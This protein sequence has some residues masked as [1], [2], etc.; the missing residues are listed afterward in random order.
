M[1]GTP[2]NFFGN[3]FAFSKMREMTRPYSIIDNTMAVKA[4]SSGGSL[5]N[6]SLQTESAKQHTTNDASNKAI[7]IAT[8][9]A[10]NN[11]SN[12][13]CKICGKSTKLVCS[14]C[15]QAWYCGKTCQTEDWKNHKLICI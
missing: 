9:N 6:I 8:N 1:R 12:N 5:Q 2:H 13:A 4:L 7:N 3:D 10:A 11:T 14:V 15:K